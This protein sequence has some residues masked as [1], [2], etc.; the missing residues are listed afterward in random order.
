MIEKEVKEK[1]YHYQGEILEHKNQLKIMEYALKDKKTEIALLN[2]QLK[3]TQQEMEVMQTRIRSYELG[4]MNMGSPTDFYLRQAQERIELLEN[5]FKQRK[6]SEYHNKGNLDAQEEIVEK[7]KQ[8]NKELLERILFLEKA[9]DVS[10]NENKSNDESKY[11][12][13]KFEKELNLPKAMERKYDQM[14]VEN[15]KGATDVQFERGNN[16]ETKKQLSDAQTKSLV[17][18]RVISDLQETI[19]H[20]EGG[21]SAQSTLAKNSTSASFLSQKVSELHQKIGEMEI[22]TRVLRKE[23]A[24]NELKIVELEKAL[25]EQNLRVEQ[26]IKGLVLYNSKLQEQASREKRNFVEYLNQMNTLHINRQQ[27]QIG[28]KHDLQ[29]EVHKFRRAI[30]EKSGNDETQKISHTSLGILTFEKLKI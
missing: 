15:P 3:K 20:L 22:E 1:T 27:N 24:E 11:E 8:R 30:L 7:L 14:I 21:G 26:E 12:N 6:N 23:K 4:Y 9:Q 13:M 16:I 29:E 18:Q 2:N 28:A 19:K 25:E 10:L 17:F 5:E